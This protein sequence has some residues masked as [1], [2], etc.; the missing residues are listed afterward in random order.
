MEI[1]VLGPQCLPVQ[2]K[3]RYKPVVLF[4]NIIA[5]ITVHFFFN[6]HNICEKNMIF[7]VKSMQVFLEEENAQQCS[8]YLYSFSLRISKIIPRINTITAERKLKLMMLR[9]H[10]PELPRSDIGLCYWMIKIR[11]V[12]FPVYFEDCE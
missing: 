6:F 5:F 3:Y 7:C 10:L 11:F 4:I 1:H 8:N 2:L 9:K 12:D